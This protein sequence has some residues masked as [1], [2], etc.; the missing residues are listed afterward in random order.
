MKAEGQHYMS[1]KQNK[2]DNNFNPYNKLPAINTKSTE[3]NSN[4][5]NQQ[6]KTRQKFKLNLEN[7][8]KYDDNF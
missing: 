7:V 6:S 5:T 3:D 1:S 4:A 8:N 2:A